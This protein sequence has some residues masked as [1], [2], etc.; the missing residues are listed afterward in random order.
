MLISLNN[1]RDCIKSGEGES[2]E[3]DGGEPDP[4]GPGQFS[5]RDLAQLGSEILDPSL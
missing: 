2:M 5:A 1:I 3:R 4:Y